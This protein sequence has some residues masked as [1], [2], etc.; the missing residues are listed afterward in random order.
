MLFRS[1]AGLLT[2][3]LRDRFGVIFRLELYETKELVQILQRDA[4]ILNIGA[5]REGLEEVAR[6]S[7]GTPRVAIRMLKRLRDFAQIEGN[8]TITFDIAARGL[9]ALEVDNRGLDKIDNQMLRSI[10][11]IFHG[12]PVGL[13]TL[14]AVTNED[15][16]TIEDVYEPYLMQLGLLAKTPRGRVLT[17][18]GWQ[19]VGLNPPDN[20][21]QSGRANGSAAQQMGLEDML[22]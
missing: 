5:N 16:T 8:G 9:L 20:L 14:A 4:S 12:G 2:A 10:A 19:H 1:R 6:R 22:N 17:D 15:A 3:P 13:D 18:L 21:T 11:E 7:R